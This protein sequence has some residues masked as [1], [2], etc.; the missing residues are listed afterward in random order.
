MLAG[1]RAGAQRHQAARCRRGKGAGKFFQPSGGA[2]QDRR[3]QRRIIGQLRQQ[4]PAHSV[5]EH[6][7]HAID[8]IEIA[9]PVGHRRPVDRIRDAEQRGRAG[10]TSQ[11]EPGIGPDMGSVWHESDACQPIAGH[12]QLAIRAIGKRLNL[13]GLQPAAQPAPVHRNMVADGHIGHG[14][15]SIGPDLKPARRGF[16]QLQRRTIPDQL[17]AQHLDLGW[18]TGTG[19]H[20][21]PG[22]P[23]IVEHGQRVL[24]GV[25]VR[26]KARPR[27]HPEHM[28]TVVARPLRSPGPASDATNSDPPAGR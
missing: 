4:V 11:I 25:T 1:L 5:D 24:G 18:V 19:N 17:P 9:D 7:R 15:I 27:V 21:A 16:G 10:S 12:A 28:K 23:A 20:R 22:D 13:F 14:A 8:L 6:D 2:G 26:Q 3:E